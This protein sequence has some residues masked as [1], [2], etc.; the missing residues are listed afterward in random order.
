MTKVHRELLSRLETVRAVN[1]DTAYAFQE[2]VPEMTEKLASYFRTS[3][4]ISLEP[5]HFASY[6]ASDDL[7]RSI[8]KQRVR[9]ANFVF[10]GPGSPSYAVQ[11]WIPLDIASDLQHV[12]ANNGTLCFSSA[13]V[14]TLGAFSPPVYE[15]YK[16]GT[17][18]YWNPGL[19]LLANYGLNCVVI[20]HFDN[21]EGANYDTSCCYLGKRRLEL[22][23]H[24]LP[25]GTATLGVDE[26]TAL[27]FDFGNDTVRVLGRS[28]GYWREN[29][30]E[31]TLKN[32]STTELAELRTTPVAPPLASQLLEAPDEVGPEAL[33][34]VASGQ[35][36]EAIE[37][38]GKLVLLSKT[39]GEGFI[40]PTS[41]LDGILKVRENA[42]KAGHYALAD[43]L[44]DA[45]IKSGIDVQDGPNG[46]TWVRNPAN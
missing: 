35:G 32:G 7:T 19:N 9:E 21:A 23:E 15:I 34:R 14:A 25:S 27:L 24:E 26:H 18:P 1:I 5:L 42:R 3:L 40:D 30:H 46:S 39:G 22:M 37:A 36:P 43:E 31:M 33:A 20:P 6:D 8:F 29:G 45:I 17:A 4:H 2:N 11:Q 10:A 38:L 44:R 41:L 16:V 28:N 13:A 12:L